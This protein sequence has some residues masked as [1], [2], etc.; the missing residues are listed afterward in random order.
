MEEDEG[1]VLDVPGAQA[2]Q[3]RPPR[4]DKRESTCLLSQVPS[5]PQD[6]VTWV[7][8]ARNVDAGVRGEE[9]VGNGP[10]DGQVGQ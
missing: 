2:S 7:L 10:R 3:E 6:D 8:C 1:I 5:I 9:G 4:D